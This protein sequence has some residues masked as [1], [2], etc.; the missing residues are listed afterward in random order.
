MVV[1]C[2]CRIYEATRS[3]CASVICTQL[4]RRWWRRKSPVGLRGLRGANSSD[5]RWPGGVSYFRSGNPT[6][7]VDL[8]AAD[9]GLHLQLSPAK[10]WLEIPGL[11]SASGL[12][13]ALLRCVT[14]WPALVRAGP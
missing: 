4:L 12:G 5:G 3:I 1:P 7:L 8:P 6:A 10:P 11:R 2:S 13:T 14:A 9:G